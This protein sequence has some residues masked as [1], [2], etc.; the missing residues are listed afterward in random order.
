MVG[1]SGRGEFEHLLF[2]VAP[3]LEEGSERADEYEKMIK[4]KKTIDPQI[5]TT[6]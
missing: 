6:C 1:G 2:V 4:G 5:A 3:L